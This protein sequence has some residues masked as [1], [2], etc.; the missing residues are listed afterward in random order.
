[1]P[2]ERVPDLSPVAGPGDGFVPVQQGDE[3][4]FGDLAPGD[5]SGQDDFDP[6]GAGPLSGVLPFDLA[7]W[8][9]AGQRSFDDLAAGGWFN[10]YAGGRARRAAALAFEASR[11]RN[12]R[13]DC[14]NL[15]SLEAGGPM[16]L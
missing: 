16:A 6:E 5:T 11:R 13:D 9:N 3:G 8:R 12:R 15:V 7:A 2:A 4:N 14:R 10:V 1:G